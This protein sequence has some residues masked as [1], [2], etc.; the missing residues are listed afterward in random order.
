[1]NHVNPSDPFFSP[2]GFGLRIPFFCMCIKHKVAERII[3]NISLILTFE[4]FS[5]IGIVCKS[6]SSKNVC[7]YILIDA[8]IADHSFSFL[9]VIPRL[10][11]GVSIISRQMTD[12]FAAKFI[13][14]TA[15]TTIFII[16]ASWPWEQTSIVLRIK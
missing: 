16:Q 7:A 10:S 9:Y 13:L 12:K 11:T 8:L 6:S 3:E 15:F 1:M 14:Y 5:S 4:K 2:F